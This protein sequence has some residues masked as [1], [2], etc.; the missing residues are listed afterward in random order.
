MASKD[1][2]ANRHNKVETPEKKNEHRHF[3]K[4]GGS[5]LTNPQIF[6]KINP[7]E[8]PT[9]G[10]NSGGNISH[11]KNALITY[12]QKELGPISKIFSEM[13]YQDEITVEYD[14][15]SLSEAKDP[16]G[17]G[18]ARIIGKMK[19]AD[20]D[21]L[22]YE[23]SKT[24]LYGI[25]SSMTTKEVDEKLSVHRS[26][27][28]S[29]PPTTT[30]SPTATARA[31][32]TTTPHSHTA[33]INCPL[34]L[35]K[36]VV[37]VV[38][39]KTAGNKRIDQ[40]KI[41]VEFAT[42]RQRQTE[43]L[44][45]FHHRMSHTIESFEM[46][47]LEKPHSAT[48]AMRF[49]QGLDNARYASMQ[50]SFANELHNGR[51]LYPTDLP[52]AVLKASRWMVSGKSSQDSLRAL[53][54]TKGGKGVKEKAKPKAKEDKTGVKCDFCGRT[55]HS[56]SSCFKYKEAQSAALA[57]TEEKQKRPP[58]PRKG[59]T[60][61]AKGNYRPPD[62]DDEEPHYCV[63]IHIKS[64]ISSILAAKRR[65]KFMD[66]E[67]LLDTGANG[68]LFT[69]PSLA[70]GIHKDDSV[71]FDGIS[72]VLSTDTVG[73]FR[74]LCRV[75]IHRD[76]IANIL[77]FSQLRQ[78]GHSITYDEGE[79]PNDDSFTVTYHGGQIRFAHRADGL[80][81][82][83]T[84]QEQTCLVTTVAENEAKYSRREVNQAR[85]ARQ[86]QRRLANP[87]DAKL[88]KAL[89]T[90]TIQNTTVTPADVTRATDIYGPSIEA[91]KGR[92]TTARA[93]PFPQ[94]TPT[95]IT[96][97]QKMYADIFFAAGNAFEI[98]IVHPIGHIICSYVDR[99]DT[100]TLRRAL[101]T[102]LG[103]YGQRRIII[104]HV[105]SDN[106]K[107]ILCM[108]QDF[109]GAGIT[110]HL[111]GPG[112]HVH[113]IERTI[114]YVKEGV[115][116]LLAGLPYPC[117]RVIFTHLVTFVAYRLNMFP[118]STRT[119]NMSAFQL[120][121][122]R[123]INAA[124]DCQLEFG[125]Y[126]QVHNRLMNN[127]V[128]T[129]RTYGAIGLG[130]SGNGTGTCIF[131]ALHNGTIFRANTFRALP[132]PSEV[133]AHL[134][135]LAAA[136]KVK[137]T[138]D[139]IFQISAL[140]NPAMEDTPTTAT[141]PAIAPAEDHHQDLTL[142]D[143]THTERAPSPPPSTH[144]ADDLP[145][146]SS[147]TPIEADR[148]GDTPMHA[149][150]RQAEQEP[151]PA[152]Y[153]DESAAP[154]ERD[155]PLCADT[156]TTVQTYND[157]GDT[158]T[159][160]AI[161]EAIPPP[162]VSAPQPYVHPTRV[163]RPPEKLNLLSVYHMTARKALKESPDE[164]LPVIRQELETLLRKKVFRGRN[165]EDLTQAQR[166]GIIRSQMNVTQKYA[167]SS[168]GNGRVK[169]KLKARLVGGGDGQDR[170]LYSRTD[171]S[172]PTASTSAILIIAQLAAAERR[173]VISLDIGS[174]Y[175]NA[176]MPKD[177]PNKLV[178][179]AIAP[180][181]A[182]IL[183]DIDPT[184]KK[185]LRTNGSIIVELD[186]A[187]YGCIESALLWYKELSS[188]LAS[189]GF[190]P[191]PYEKCILNKNQAGGQT[192]IA[193]YVD[194]LLI[195]SPK[196]AQAEAVVDALRDKYKELKVNTGKTHNYLGM[197]LDF[198]KPPYVTINQIGMIEDIIRKARDSPSMKIPT[199][200]P[201]SPSIEQLFEASP[202]S[203]PLSEEA[204]TAFHSLLAK[205]NFVAGRARPD[206]LTTLAFLL[207]RVL[208]PTEE[209]ARKLARYIGY[210]AST[211]DLTLRLRCHLPPKITT[212][213]DASFA[214]HSNMRSHSGVCITLG[215]GAYYSKSTAQ[216]L[217][218]TSSCEAELVALSKSLQQSLWSAYFI[219]NQGYPASPI[220]VLQDN[221]STIKL[222]ENGRP[223]S[224]L[225][226]HIRIGYFWLHDLIDK[227]I[228][229]LVY[230]PTESM[231]A[232]IMTK[233]LQGSLFR[234][235]RDRIMGAV[236]CPTT[237]E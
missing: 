187:L 27:I 55:N 2:G 186:Q 152:D 104:R 139:P 69:N 40:D 194:D 34:S 122:N 124:I 207:K 149:D 145:P 53:A 134:T 136:D 216:K 70:K 35:W 166:K 62:S 214:T 85:D 38:T 75:H 89:T 169:D 105:Y 94:E 143:V 206:L 138:K 162:T 118:S 91:L 146:P 228:I 235:M 153:T 213:I 142:L 141:E 217:N 57:A 43:S 4:P 164:A 163:R 154:E 15:A 160:T 219:E 211:S 202:D 181:I 49:I 221:Q 22:A 198:S 196:Q 236:P 156:T 147:P 144:R 192:T 117:P 77:S 8:L 204:Q 73:D 99:T 208:G 86:L 18:K 225:S 52:S 48:Q 92:T 184:Y 17:I 46:L 113:I 191:N 100:P 116:G 171:T 101:R 179:M 157:I 111:A 21:N 64:R 120:V 108:G 129:P 200:S 29:E 112:M 137:I 88:I 44:S 210:A 180:I 227:K 107:G 230:C 234:T 174:A 39:T 231:I 59:T 42:I 23:K 97:E 140:R 177:D 155:A 24:K 19:Q 209:D 109:A 125:A 190:V 119:D 84:R 45:D 41:T 128:D 195:T 76:A 123:H 87:P 3:K 50:T 10:I 131:Y 60:M 67:V 178:F 233:P 197:V 158:T 127:T 83:D 103:T 232:D 148:G 47:G 16:L 133:I 63:N 110:L 81:V 61:V 26:T 9:I 6:K 218:T 32:S 168:D 188:F 226:R 25:I 205:F 20:I 150:D 224:E 161:M 237:E 151:T 115:R 72:G 130:Q 173:H 90:G 33:F 80:Y 229:K 11:I 78:M 199:V 176:K 51:D 54:A 7:S 82:H 30:A 31:P 96:A 14:A 203:P 98:T 12:C 165:Y 65:V 170:N 68:S 36:D 74:G 159:P 215:T 56:V 172:S 114:R 185:F 66:W 189:I 175:L 58:G 5:D 71:S 28:E 1:K 121:F 106:E 212:F 193:I 93:L 132:M 13:R 167:P 222:V 135:R 102:H 183:I 79:S 37:H 201:K 220:T 95:R 223:T 126:Y 182:D